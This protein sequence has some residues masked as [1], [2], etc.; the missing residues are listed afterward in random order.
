MRPAPITPILTSVQNARGDRRIPPPTGDGCYNLNVSKATIVSGEDFDRLAREDKKWRA[1]ENEASRGTTLLTM[2]AAILFLA[3]LS[4]G[5]LWVLLRLTPDISRGDT[6]D[7][8]WLVPFALTLLAAVPLGLALRRN[9][10][11]GSLAFGAAIAAS[12]VVLLVLC[13]WF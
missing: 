12:A 4:V 6:F 3:M 9:R 2:T 13:P 7:R 5:P 11:R 8:Y 10:T 1:D